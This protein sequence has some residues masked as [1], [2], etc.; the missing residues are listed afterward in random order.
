MKLTLSRAQLRA[1]CAKGRGGW[2]QAVQVATCSCC[3]RNRR[4]SPLGP[5]PSLQPGNKWCQAA[6]LLRMILEVIQWHFTGEAYCPVLTVWLTDEAGWHQEL[7]WFEPRYVL[8]S[9]LG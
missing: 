1:P 4:I 7:S 6:R 8:R 5:A 2:S 3:C 9:G